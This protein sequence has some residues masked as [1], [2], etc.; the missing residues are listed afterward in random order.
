MDR[1]RAIEDRRSS[2][3]VFLGKW[4]IMVVSDGG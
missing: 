3:F 1:Y 2:G 4:R